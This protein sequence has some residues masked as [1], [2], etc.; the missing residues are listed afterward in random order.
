MKTTNYQILTNK[1]GFVLVKSTDRKG[2]QSYAH[3]FI[4]Y[5]EPGHSF[6]ID[7]V[8]TKEKVLFGCETRISAIEQCLQ[9]YQERAVR[10]QPSIY[11]ALIEYKERELKAYQ[12]LTDA[13][14]EDIAQERV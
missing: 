11:P 9:T 3:G 8:G 14:L 12:E 13:L 1:N 7:Q 2:N 10:H 4:E 5:L 6:P